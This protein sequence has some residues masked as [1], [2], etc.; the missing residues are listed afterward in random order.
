MITCNIQWI[1]EQGNPTPDTNPAIGIV[2]CH[3][4][5]FGKEGSRP[6]FI[7]AEHAKRLREDELSDWRLHM[8]EQVSENFHFNVKA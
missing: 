5:S 6:F 2:T 4:V 8:P 1:D 3:S 7:C